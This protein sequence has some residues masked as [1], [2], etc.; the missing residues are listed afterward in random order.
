MYLKVGIIL[1]KSNPQVI[2]ILLPFIL[3]Y[4]P[5]YIILKWQV[6]YNAWRGDKEAVEGLVEGLMNVPH[7]TR[8]FCPF[9]GATFKQSAVV[10]FGKQ[11]PILSLHVEEFVSR[12]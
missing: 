10:F 4:L 6:I 9:N 2:Y 1:K 5:I 7:Q 8:V 11:E 3:Y 12:L